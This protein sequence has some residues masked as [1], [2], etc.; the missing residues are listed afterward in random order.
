[1]SYTTI[2]DYFLLPLQPLASGGAG[3]ARSSQ[4]T[5]EASSIWIMI[6][7]AQLGVTIVGF[8]E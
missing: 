4:V 1:M 7:A 2:Y 8:P 6:G 3:S 5:A